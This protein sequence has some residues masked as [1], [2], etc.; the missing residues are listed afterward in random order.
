MSQLIRRAGAG[1]LRAGDPIS[2]R[3]VLAG[4][5]LAGLLFVLWSCQPGQAVERSPESGSLGQA[6]EDS[7]CPECAADLIEQLGLREAPTPVRERPGWSPPRRIVVF[8]DEARVERLRQAVPGV[9]F[10]TAAYN[11]VAGGSLS[12][13]DV[14]IGACSPEIVSAAS[15][16]K[17]I[18]LSSAGAERCVN[19]PGIRERGILITNAQRLYGPEIAEHVIAMLFAFSRGLYRYIPAQQQGIWDRN[20]LSASQIWELEGRTLLVVGLGGIGTQVA[21]RADALGMRVLATRRSSRDAWRADALGM[22]VLATR[23]SSREGPEFVDYVGTTDELINLAQRADVVVNCTPLTP[24]T[25]GLFDAEFFA[26]MKQTAYFINV[27][28]GKSVVTA[29]LL[30]ALESGGIAGAGLDVTDPEPLPSGHL[31]WRLPNVIIT[32]HMS[33]MSDRRRDRLW[34]LVEE[35]LRRYV[36]GERMLSVVDVERGY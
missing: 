33:G 20:I 24:A 2:F 13:A 6:Q 11:R 7:G 28:R 10:V 8:A 14:I 29:D 18:Q 16:V 26:A 27:G 25:T 35:N 22:R 17:W 23:R 12:E 30:V 36:A 4:L 21:W 3:H 9:E 34:V 31:L 19:I 5:L 1:V 15:N 32:P